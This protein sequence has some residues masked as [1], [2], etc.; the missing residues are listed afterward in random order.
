[1]AQIEKEKERVFQEVSEFI[2]LLETIRRRKYPTPHLEKFETLIKHSYEILNEQLPEYL[3]DV[4]SHVP[5]EEASRRIGELHFQI[6]TLFDVMY[7][8]LLHSSDVPQ[9]LYFLSDTFLN[10]CEVPKDYIIFVSDEIAMFSF[11]D[12]LESIGFDPE[13]W[14]KMYERQFYFVQTVPEFN[15]KDTS[16]DWP[17]ILHEMAHIVCDKKG[18]SKRYLAQLSIRDALYIVYSAERHPEFLVVL[19]RRKLYVNE[20]LADLLVTRCFAAIYGWRFLK[21]YVSLRDVFEPGRS[22]P[23]PSH[24]LQKISSEVNT[25]LKMPNSSRFLDQELQSWT[26]EVASQVEGGV[27]DINVDDILTNVLDEVYN[28][29]QYMLTYEQVERSIRASAWFQMLK[30]NEKVEEK[31]NKNLDQFLQQLQDQLLKGIPIVIDPPSLYFIATLDFSNIQ[32]ISELDNPTKE[33]IREMI[34][35]CIRLY[36]VQHRFLTEVLPQ[37]T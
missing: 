22:H 11:H 19:A 24:R 17:I 33:A 25:K 36:A 9:E 8:A 23:S 7:R 13:F 32:K 6:K 30:G 2:S 4:T 27:P 12:V 16:L 35:D 18:T 28:Y 29:S 31:L 34:A 14:S 26:R 1:M 10:L 37:T 3:R 20:H 15:K 21:R 5:P